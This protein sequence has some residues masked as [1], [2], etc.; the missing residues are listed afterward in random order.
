MRKSPPIALCRP[1]VWRN[2]D[3]GI[4]RCLTI[5][6]HSKCPVEAPSKQ[7]LGESIMIYLTLQHPKNHCWDIFQSLISEVFPSPWQSLRSFEGDFSLRFEIIGG[8]RNVVSMSYRD[9]TCTQKNTWHDE[10]WW[11][12]LIRTFWIMDTWVTGSWIINVVLTGTAA[13]H[14]DLTVGICTNPNMPKRAETY[15]LW[16]FLWNDPS[17]SFHHQFFS[18]TWG[19]ELELEGWRTPHRFHIWPCHLET[20]LNVV[21]ETCHISVGSKFCTLQVLDMLFFFLQVSLTNKTYKDVMSHFGLWDHK[22]HRWRPVPKA[23]LDG[24]R[25][26]IFG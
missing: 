18:A 16:S 5:F 9:G 23:G 1:E 26:T 2:L 3:H 21:F 10:S 22:V 15:W 19:S 14:T 24:T 11:E 25:G 20:D 8:W 17:P 7:N 6:G 13:W 12:M 4:R